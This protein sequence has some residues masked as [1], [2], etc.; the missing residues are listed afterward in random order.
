MSSAQTVAPGATSAP[1][2][3]EL[4]TSSGTAYTA[5]LPVTVS[6]SS[7]SPTGELFDEPRRTVV[8]DARVADRRPARAP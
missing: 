2:T 7:S 3:I 1:L 5:G 4:E 6:L 8:S